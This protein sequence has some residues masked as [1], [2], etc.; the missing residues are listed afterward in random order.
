[1]EI[2]TFATRWVSLEGIMLNTDIFL[3]PLQILKPNRAVICLL[4]SLLVM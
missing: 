4:L 1:M 3:K 2:L